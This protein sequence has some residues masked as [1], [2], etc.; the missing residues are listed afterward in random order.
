MGCILSVDYG[1]KRIGLAVSDPEK[2]FAFPLDTIE[3]K[4][5]KFVLSLIAKIIED[6]DIDLIIVGVPYRGKPDI[7]DSDS[8]E[9]LITGF[10]N[11]LKENVSIPVE[12]IDESLSSFMAEERLR[13][14]GKNAKEIKSIIDQ[15]AAR[16]ILEDYIQ[17]V[18]KH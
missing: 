12:A 13:E 6:K 18:K 3:N 15:E 17:N 1:L 11:R 4:N 16:Y 5:F 7:T 2:I 10:I 9:S 14:S 8:M